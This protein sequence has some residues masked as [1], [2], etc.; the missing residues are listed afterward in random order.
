MGMGFGGGAMWNMGGVAGGNHNNWGGSGQ[1]TAGGAPFAGIPD[2]LVEEVTELVE[3]EP[4]HG[5]PDA[6]F[7]A[8]STDRRILTLSRL[9]VDR[10]K[11]ATAALIFLTIE[12][13]GFQTGP[14]LTKIGI[15]SGVHAGH[16]HIVVEC[17]VAYLASVLITVLVERARVRATGRLAAQVMNDLRVKVFAH[18]QRLSLDYFTEEKAGVIMTRMTSDIEVLQQLLQDGL[19][20]FAIQGLTMVVVTVIL[21]AFNW[22]LALITVAVVMPVLV[23][24]S[25]WFR[26]ASER[27]YLRVRDTLAG[28]ISDIAESLSGVR[29]VASYNRQP[30][31][32]VHHRNVLGAYREANNKTARITAAYSTASDFIGLGGQ[33]VLL[34]VGGEMVVH[35]TLTIGELTAFILYLGSF[36]QPIQ[37][38]VQ[39]YNTYQQGQAAVSK[40]RTLLSTEP[41]VLEAED[42]IELPAIEG[43]ITL[44]DV[45]FGYDPSVPV[46]ADVNLKI[47]AG[48][49]VSFV[50]AT[51]AGKSTIAKLVTRFYDPT[52]G[53]VLIDGH[54]LTSV[55][56]T[57]LRR[58]LGVVP[59][60]PFLFTGTIRDNIAFTRP[61]ASEAEVLEAIDAV[62]LSELMERL[63][64]GVDTAVHER[65]QSL[66]SGERQ[67]IAL[68]RAFLAGPRVLVLDE[69]TSNL[70]LKSESKVEAA[71]DRVLEGRTAILIA[72]RLTTA[73]RADRIVVVDNG[74][75]IEVGSHDEL[76]AKGGRYAEMYETW[77]RQHED[78]E[79]LEEQVGT[80][81]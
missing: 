4:D 5:E 77:S 79:E 53:R 38:L 39:L 7:T 59:Q 44:E 67:L 71:L 12:T 17:G 9:I 6:V 69:A 40:L 66:A 43:E 70:D 73:M 68:A 78:E 41:T 42:A 76:V 35:H 36:F 31:N 56:L 1:A 11:L 29:I 72:H 45:E 19:A 28:V 24:A 74:R 52:K 22:L 46:L 25:L 27:G 58:Q 47:R 8:R 16:L 60:E 15:D 10:W 23:F 80:H 21:F 81:G 48:E 62:G 50:G 2:E 63:P 30:N 33:L 49:C 75:I 61:A 3:T 55:T 37:Q 65:G 64:Y 18:I 32:V 14:Y 51:G 20:Q 34:L 57:S 26:S 13:I 54:P